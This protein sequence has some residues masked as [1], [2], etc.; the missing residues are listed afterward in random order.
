MTAAFGKYAPFIVT[1]YGLVAVVVFGMIAG[2]AIDYRRQRAAL[3]DLETRGVTRR[4]GSEKNS[5]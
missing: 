4:S 1:S 3:R 2:I 5:S